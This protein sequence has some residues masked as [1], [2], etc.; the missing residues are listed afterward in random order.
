MQFDYVHQKLGEAIRLALF[1]QDPAR[2]ADAFSAI[3]ALHL[4]PQEIAASLGEEEAR[5]RWLRLLERTTPGPEEH[6][7]DLAARLS[8]QERSDLGVDLYSV[9]ERVSELLYG[10][11][12]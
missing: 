8:A 1:T 4:R 12:R 2:L 10:A 7:A 9:N 11:R 3:H 5:E 6:Y